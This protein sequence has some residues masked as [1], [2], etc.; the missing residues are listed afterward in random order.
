MILMNNIKLT[1]MT[2]FLFLCAFYMLGSTMGYAQVSP[3]ERQALIDLYNATDGP[4]WKN[5][6]ANDEPWLINDPQSLVDDWYGI[7][8][9]NGKVVDMNLY[10][11][12]LNGPIPNSIEDL[13][14]LKFLTLSN[15]GL[16]G[17]IPVGLTQM[18]NLLRLALSK[19]DLSGSVPGALFSGLPNLVYLYLDYNDFTGN[20][21]PEIGQLTKA[22][23]INMGGNQFSGSI[24]DEI[25]QLESLKTLYLNSNALTGTIPSSI[26]DLA[27]LRKIS[28]SRNKLTGPI[29][30]TI[31]NLSNL[32]D[33][34]MFL[35]DLTGTIPAD[36][37]N[38][39]DLKLVH[40]GFNDLEG[41][42]PSNLGN[43]SKLTYFYVAGND[44][45]GEIPR[46]LGNWSSVVTLN[47]S[48][49]H[50][51]GKI[52]NELAALTS[53]RYLNL[54]RNNFVFSDL[55]DNHGT[56]LDNVI[57]TYKYIP[58]GEVSQ[59]ETISAIE[60][61]DITLMS[62][63]TS[64]NNSYQWFKT[65][66]GTTT[67]I[68]G[69]TNKDLELPN[70][71]VSDSGT[72][73]CTVTNTVVTGLT[74]ERHP[75][76]L[77]ITPNT[78]NISVSEKEALWDLYSAANGANWTNTLANDKPW[79]NCIP[80]CD[81]YGVTVVDGKV[82]ELNLENNDLQ[83]NI[84]S[85]I[86]N[87][88]SLESLNLS[89][90]T[91]TGEIP[92][93]LGA[94][95][96]LTYLSLHH[97]NLSGTLSPSLGSLSNLTFMDLS[98]NGTI[99]GP[100]PIAFCNLA[101]LTTLN[102][103]NNQLSGG[104]PKQLGILTQLIRLDLNNNELVG[105]I[106]SQLASLTQLEFLG[107]KSNMLS[108]VIP[109]FVGESSTL[110]TFVFEDNN[111]IFSDFET[112]HP[113]Y[114]QYVNTAYQY[115][116][117]AKVDME[118]IKTVTVGNNIA[119]TTMLSSAN[120]SYQWYKN[121]VLVPGA[122]SREYVIENATLE[123]AG[124][125]HFIATNS[126]IGVLTLIRNAITLDVKDV[127]N[128]STTERLALIDFFN[129]TGGGSWKNTIEGNQSWSIDDVNSKVCDWFG[130]V[131]QD[132]KVVE[133]NLNGNDLSGI[134]PDVFANLPSLKKINV[135]TN[136][137]SGNVP[138]SI[139]ALSNLETLAIENN[140]YV[141]KD[142]E[143]EFN[144]YSA[145]NFSY[146]PQEDV[147]AFTEES[148]NF[149]SSITLTSSDLTSANNQY[150]WFRYGLP[151]EGA[152]SKDLVITNATSE[153]SGMYF[154]TATNTTVTGLTLT[155]KPISVNVFPE[156]DTCGVSSVE[157]QALMDFYNSTNGASW[158]NNTN[159]LTDAPV[160]EWFGVTVENGKVTKLSLISNN[161]E[162]T[163]PESLGDLTSLNYVALAINK[164]TGN[165]PASIG[166][167]INLETFS[168]E[169]NAMSGPIPSSIGNMA[170]LKILI[171]GTNQFNGAI[172]TEI[173]D[174]TNLTTLN[175]F[176]NKLSEMIPSEIGNLSKLVKLNLFGNTLTGEIPSSL[177]DLS[178]LEILNLYINKLD[179]PIPSSIGNLSKL[180]VL[181]LFRN[182]LTGEIPASLGNLSSLITLNLYLNELEGDV[183]QEL[184]NL[185]ALSALNMSSNKLSGKIP[186]GFSQLASSNVLNTLV[187]GTNNFVFSNFE[188]EH[189]IYESNL[190]TYGYSPQAKVDEQETKSVMEGG[191]ITLTSNALTST[192]N[193]Y[194]WFK[195]NVAIEGATNK[196]LV[197]SNAT[198]SDSGIYHFSA[199][200]NIVGGLTLTRHSITLNVVA[201]GI[202]AVSEEDRLALI[203]FYQTTNGNGW[204]NTTEGNQPWLIDDPASKVCDWYGITISSDFKIEA[205][206]LPSNNLRGEIP[207]SLETLTRLEA[208][209]LSDNEMIGEI[210]M[211][212]GTLPKLKTLNLKDNILVGA[213]PDAIS[214]LMTLEVLD[215]GGNRFLSEIPTTIGMLQNL[216]Y[217]DLSANKLEGAIPD[218]LWT[219]PTL[220]TI[221]L[222]DNKLSGG[223]S[224][225]IGN[226]SQLQ[227]FWVSKNNFN[228]TIPQTITLANTPNLYSVHLDHNA[229]SGDLPQLIP[230]LSLPNTSVQINDNAFIFNDFELEFP[231]YQSELTN[232][233]YS[234]QAFVDQTEIKY[235]ELGD[236]V[237][238][239]SNQLI[240]TNNV[241]QWYKRNAQGVFEPIPGAIDKDY[242]ITG[243][244]QE[245]FGQYRFIATNTVVVG[246]ELTRRTI[247]LIEFV[248]TDG[249]GIPD[250]DDPDDDN[251][252]CPDE[253][254]IANG[255]DPL[256]PND[257]SCP[258][259][260]YVFCNSLSSISIGDLPVPNGGN[261]AIWF[262]NGT[263]LVPIPSEE[264]IFISQTLWA[265][266]DG[267][268]T[269]VAVPISVNDGAPGIFETVDENGV[270]ID[271]SFQVFNPS[272]N[273]TIA[274]LK[275]TP[276]QGITWYDTSTSTEVLDENTMLVDGA[277]YY[278]ALNGHPCRFEVE[279]F[280]GVPDVF[281]EGIQHFCAANAPTLA[282]I[283]VIKPN[284]GNELR[285]Y[286]SL[287]DGML[288][289]ETTP[290][291]DGSTYFVTQYDG[292]GE[293]EVRTPVE[294]VVYDVQFPEYFTSVQTIFIKDGQI[295]TIGDLLDR[296]PTVIWYQ[297]PEGDTPYNSSYPL[298]DGDTYYAAQLNREA[299]CE[300]DIRL[301]VTIN[302]IQEQ[303]PILVGCEKFKP[304]PGYRY[305]ISGWVREQGVK[306]VNVDTRNFIADKPA[307]D[308][309]LELL[310]HLTKDFVLNE[311][312]KKTVRFIRE[313]YIPDT[314]NKVYD[315]ILPYVID[316]PTDNLTIYNFK[317]VKED[318]GYERTIGFQF[319]FSPDATGDEYDFR[320]VTPAYETG[321]NPQRYP[322]LN[323]PSIAVEF[324][325]FSSNGNTLEAVSTFS[326]DTSS[327][328]NGEALLNGSLS[329]YK[330][331]FNNLALEHDFL[332]YEPDL[333]YQVMNYANSLIEV[334]YEDEEGV[335]LDLDEGYRVA[336]QPKGAVMDGWQRIS[337]DFV[338]PSE[339]AFMSIVLK[340]TNGEDIN[341]YFDD[342]RIHPFDSNMKT[343]V[344]D[345]QTQR[346][347]SELDENNYATFY[348]YDKEGGLIRV[349]KETERGVF[350]IQETRSGNSKLNNVEE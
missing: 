260:D 134:L 176:N 67:E 160:C 204:T 83:G 285:W 21:P 143:T 9:E 302:I 175:L 318:V 223:I 229:F 153:N 280:L 157:K 184:G 210:P 32:T 171:L 261:T 194:Q 45:E 180:T 70:A 307:S 31:A 174:L 189:Q 147:D 312:P 208:L 11:N 259:G 169:R 87:L 89:N 129:A 132:N 74:L 141:F 15:N 39:L 10:K 106:P 75:I 14:G 149:G 304:Q 50:F 62:T 230:N 232:F 193:T 6:L 288:L 81:W 127:C 254:E 36:L 246:L 200:N 238:L 43:L 5:T 206:Q 120:N 213:I 27:E 321:N 170:A 107:L 199:T 332:T 327:P 225:E 266:I 217:L 60:G 336:F 291:V 46:E 19:N 99:G 218:G 88:S 188:T 278:A 330:T 345:P 82:T 118:E 109:F 40:L 179:G 250:P 187:F 156:G 346:L 273:P 20:I 350:T 227:V 324:T 212:L 224:D 348:E 94:L 57:T 319:S 77:Q 337:A 314:E 126:V 251:D 334:V 53:I 65:V 49:N 86:S 178:Q 270:F 4:N 29:P 26:G 190:T 252:D 236:D 305:V 44:L 244:A 121:N 306:I 308:R 167:L 163:I 101:N 76:T 342:I 110:E 249:D 17:G 317:Y 215:L 347:Q 55:E 295:A 130:V 262:E 48:S 90:N 138:S 198:S 268:S 144:T 191:S 315:A 168:V 139:A 279:V 25:G 122:T 277:F 96:E 197:I 298:I 23:F 142:F 256:D 136:S 51:T 296:D 338:V 159:W 242:I 103:S 117:Q 128:V 214:N 322:L 146:H 333:G 12:D 61:C 52:P 154:F 219:I 119:L 173:G 222:Q 211:A 344:Y 152:T 58:Q 226:L 172:P 265:E 63:L 257:N 221:K 177:G 293:S 79:S 22:I 263:D 115:Q 220:Q 28:L 84:P 64:T 8:V 13:Q 303:P 95:I 37:G 276:S 267:N 93:S 140:G 205:I 325:G 201:E 216:E 329:N 3:E 24:P 231:Q 240:S 69:A 300:S 239:T 41:A 323:N 71:S 264:E 164:L 237:T 182:E 133:L 105:V 255:S 326:I 124:I 343:F 145:L 54:E 150:Q 135:N 116:P 196:E 166:D 151:I 340:N 282:S 1:R 91:L 341:S 339:A 258:T 98:H 207:V 309:L 269:R 228:G 290:L 294:V 38:L 111:F 195:G 287:T 56:L 162:G 235:L 245:Q 328:G 202:C 113:N 241:Y 2:R 283:E 281:A 310:N 42:L 59:I 181:N 16:N 165:L 284:Q 289:P 183:P 104:I 30:T 209:D 331:S 311:E 155:R 292:I 123:D 92:A 47:L 192:N 253:I 66:N 243:I 247:T 186:S 80:V 35:N 301:A 85:T 108:G 233:I 185:P 72:Y 131:V 275:I 148:I 272:T 114:V 316:G 137:L 271:E 125:Y 234:P 297:T 161:L 320:Y 274:N 203:D 349:K 7:R 73:H 102:L 33:L 158:T 248:D 34:S 100:I 18:P 112:K 286:D 78:C 299:T 97:N 68:T 335:E 313:S